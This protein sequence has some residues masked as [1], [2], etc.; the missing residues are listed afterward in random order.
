[1]TLGAGDEDVSSCVRACWFSWEGREKETEIYCGIGQASCDG[2][3]A[4]FGGPGV[5]PSRVVG[6]LSVVSSNICI[7]IY[8]CT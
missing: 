1:M 4:I 7:Y 2:C 8:I 3:S 6:A 5:V